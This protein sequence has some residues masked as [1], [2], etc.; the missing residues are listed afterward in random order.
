[1]ENFLIKDPET[2]A[3]KRNVL[4]N[5]WITP[6]II[7]SIK[8]KQHYYKMWNRTRDLKNRHGDAASYLTYKNYRKLLKSII[9]MAKIRYYCKK[10]ECV[11]GNTKK[12]WA[13]INEL[14]GK[15]KPKLKASIL[16]NNKIVTDKNE[17]SNGFNKFFSSIA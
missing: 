1:M 2:K 5:P 4:V 17:I 9:A 14:R 8:K 10:F 7:A 11:K 6:G 13:L 3:Y 12:M 15:N 16:I